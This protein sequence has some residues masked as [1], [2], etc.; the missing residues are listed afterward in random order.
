[1]LHI[2]D[3]LASPKRERSP[4]PEA[5]PGMD[6][7]RSTCL[8]TRAGLLDSN[9]GRGVGVR[10]L[11]GQSPRPTHT[12]HLS[13][14]EQPGTQNVQAGDS[15]SR[16]TH[17][18]LHPRG[19][20]RGGDG[21][22]HSEQHTDATHPGSPSSESAQPQEAAE[23]TCAKNTGAKTR[24]GERL[25]TAVTPVRHVNTPPTH[26]AGRLLVEKG[27][28]S[29]PGT[30][31]ARTQ[32]TSRKT[33]WRSTTESVTALGK[34]FAQLPKKEGLGLRPYGYGDRPPPGPRGP[35]RPGNGSSR[36]G[37]AQA[38][39]RLV[40]AAHNCQSSGG[41]TATIRPQGQDAGTG[42]AVTLLHRR[43]SE[44]GSSR[45]ETHWLFPS[46]HA[47]TSSMAGARPGEEAVMRYK[48]RN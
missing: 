11:T 32:R 1:M 27:S 8:S 6:F 3:V 35:C 19:G 41:G 45:T 17:E 21:S 9:S 40:R 5:S 46:Q 39:P 13:D 20:G 22:G 7:A 31:A 44:C 36:C 25:T 47:S 42:V 34:N 24:R 2:T 29:D 48:K 14:T 16:Q 30:K 23:V 28:T 43:H 18:S 38:R 33:R 12:V 4:C 10:W 15:I 26:Q 37:A